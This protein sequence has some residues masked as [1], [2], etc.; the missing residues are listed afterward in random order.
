LTDRKHPTPARTITVNAKAV[1]VG[2]DGVGFEFIL[3]T[4]KRK[5]GEL[6]PLEERTLGMDAERLEAFLQKLKA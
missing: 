3:G 1:R 4:E 2:R 5:K 6:P